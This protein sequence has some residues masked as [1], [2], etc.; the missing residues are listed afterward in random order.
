MN[1][2]KERS[3]HQ[4]VSAWREHSLHVRSRAI[5]PADVLENVFGNYEVK[6]LW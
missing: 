4:E 3:R 6:S 1:P 5:R 2:V